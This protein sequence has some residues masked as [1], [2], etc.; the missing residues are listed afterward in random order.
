MKLYDKNGNTIEELSYDT[1]GRRRDSSTWQLLSSAS[2]PSSLI[3]R[4]YTQHEHLDTFGLININGRLYDPVVGRMLNPDNYV[5]DS[6]S[7]QPV[8][9]ISISD[10]IGSGIDKSLNV[11]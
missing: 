1:W 3:S 9:G 4:G 2:N 6:I 10:R 8:I 7:S 5:Q 11:N